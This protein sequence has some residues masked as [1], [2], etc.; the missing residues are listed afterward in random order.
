MSALP[1]L[2]SLEQYM[3]DVG[4]Y[5]VLDREQERALAIRN[6]DGDEEARETLI[7]HN[8]RFVI[9][10]ARKY[11]APGVD[12]IDLI[13]AG[14]EGLI[15]AVDRFDP[16][17]DVKLISY[18]TYW[19]R[20]SIRAWLSEHSHVCRLPV[21][22][23]TEAYRIRR[24]R[25][26]LAERLDRQ[27]TT[28]EVAE[29]AD[30]SPEMVSVVNRLENPTSL[31]TPVGDD[32][33][34]T[35]PT[36][37]ERIPSPEDLEADVEIESVRANLKDAVDKALSERLARIIRL[38]FGLGVARDHSLE[39][40]GQIEDVSRER[41]RQLEDQALERLREEADPVVLGECKATL[42]S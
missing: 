25:N 4:R 7:R 20:Q 42:L 24:V 1:E 39:E 13:Q 31:D 29:E 19:I 35:P 14:N 5:D 12:L 6:R 3:R 2:N 23:G 17:Q 30:V 11:R 21:N 15:R 10:E 33:D 9:T 27:P 36:L 22:R 32:S 28:E 37:G 16:T 40:I 8:L 26:E 34:R 38:R 41:I 18:A